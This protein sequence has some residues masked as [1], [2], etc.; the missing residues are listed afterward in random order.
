LSNNF[1]QNWKFRFAQT[2]ITIEV[3]REFGEGLP[4]W[5]IVNQV[6]NAQMTTALKEQVDLGEA[7]I[8]ALALENEDHL[9]IIDDN[10]GRKLAERL[11]LNYTGTLGILVKAKK[12]GM[13]PLLKPILE[14]IE[15][16][17]LRLSEKLKN[18]LL[19]AV[20]VGE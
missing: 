13:I 2:I 19:K 12:E 4:D 8:I 10:K 14:K 20:G 11:S 18:I 5:I 17:D 15:E 3:K 16:T 7:S 9:V 1:G 6:Q